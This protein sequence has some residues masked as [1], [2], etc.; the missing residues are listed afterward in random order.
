[1]KEQILL[2]WGWGRIACQVALAVP[3]VNKVLSYLTCQFVLEANVFFLL[4]FSIRP[5]SGLLPVLGPLE[6]YM[7]PTLDWAL[8]ITSRA[9]ADLGRTSDRLESYA[10]P[11]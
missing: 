10:S 7:T 3:H 1:M 4:F 11:W 5:P 8:L 6:W 9:G 2:A